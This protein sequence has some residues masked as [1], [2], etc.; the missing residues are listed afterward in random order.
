MNGIINYSIFILTY[1]YLKIYILN[2]STN[3]EIMTIKRLMWISIFNNISYPSMVIDV[4][5]DVITFGVG[6]DMTSAIMLDVDMLSG[7]EII[8]MATPVIT[9]EFVVGVVCAVDV[10]SDLL[11]AVLIID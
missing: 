8:A 9:L 2:C 6:V 10:L 3:T 5:A 4:L 1:F 7:M 11:L